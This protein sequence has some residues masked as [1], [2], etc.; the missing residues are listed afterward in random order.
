MEELL[1]LV[2]DYAVPGQIQLRFII[3]M[4]LTL[5]LCIFEVR[6]V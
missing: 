1:E 3:S 6:L 5:N 4:E 2:K